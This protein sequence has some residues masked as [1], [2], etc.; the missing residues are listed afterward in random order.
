MLNFPTDS[1]VDRYQNPLLNRQELLPLKNKITELDKSISNTE[2]KKII[3]KSLFLKY[4]ALAG[5]TFTAS[6]YMNPLLAAF[7]VAV[8]THTVLKKIEEHL[9]SI[10]RKAGNE[11]DTAKRTY[12]EHSFYAVC[13][14]T[15][16]ELDRDQPKVRSR[17]KSLP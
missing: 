16:S 8:V 1:S 14:A 15:S 12:I 17:S 9:N 13:R 5:L 7:G 2:W 11:F 6:N 4:I 3:I 10:L